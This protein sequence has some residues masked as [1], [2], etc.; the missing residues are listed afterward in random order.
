MTITEIAGGAVM[1][2]GK[3]NYYRLW[4]I[5]SIGRRLILNNGRYI[6]LFR[7]MVTFIIFAIIFSFISNFSYASLKIKDSEVKKVYIITTE[8]DSWVT[9]SIKDLKYYLEKVFKVEKVELISPSPELIEDDAALIY[10]GINEEIKSKFPEIQDLSIDGYII[11]SLTDGRGILITGKTPDG[12]ANGIY[13]FL[14]DFIG[15]RWFLPDEIFTYIPEK[16]PNIDLTKINTKV[17]PSFIPRLFSGFTGVDGANWA[18]RNRVD[19]GR[20]SLP[21]AAMSHNLY[22]IF[23]KEKFEKTHPEYFPLI[24][25]KRAIPEKLDGGNPQPC[26]SNPEV[27]DEA[28]KATLEFFKEN[29][30]AIT[31]SLSI[32]DTNTWCECKRCRALDGKRRFYREREIFSDRY[33]L[34]LN[35]I[36]KRLKKEMPGKFIGALAYS[37]TELPPRNIAKLSDNIGIWLTQ[38]TSQQ[39]DANYKRIDQKII[40]D[41]YKKG[42]RISK[43]DYYGLSW[44]TPRYYPHLIAEDIK[45]CKGH[46]VVGRFTEAYP[47]WATFGPMEYVGV[48]MQWNTSLDVDEL[49]NEFYKKMFK[50]S[51]SNI[52]NFYSILEKQWMKKRKGEWF[53]GLGDTE[54]HLTQ[55]P[56]NVMEKAKSELD[57]AKN[58]ILRSAQNDIYI[59]QRIEF[60]E[61]G[62]N[63]S[64]YLVKSYNAVQEIENNKKHIDSGKL[65]SLSNEYYTS[66]SKAKENY[67]N[68]IETKD[69]YPAPYY[70]G[71]DYIQ[72]LTKW[73]NSAKEKIIDNL[74]KLKDRKK[75][76][77]R[78][79]WSKIEKEIIHPDVIAFAKVKL[80]LDKMKNLLQDAGFEGT[81]TENLKWIREGDKFDT[82][83]PWFVWKK[84]EGEKVTPL[85]DE[86]FSHSGKKSAVISGETKGAFIQIIPVKPGEQYFLSTYVYAN[87]LGK[88]DRLPEFEIEWRK[89]DASPMERIFYDLAKLKVKKSWENVQ[90]IATVPEGASFGLVLLMI[91]DESPTQKVWFDDVFIGKIE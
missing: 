68:Y 10:V 83:I 59:K 14:E 46:G 77:N 35:E 45:F 7:A 19:R 49:L 33:F 44:Q 58:E 24:E 78:T 26:M 3:I 15:I 64:Y 91:N 86:S 16:E 28:Y 80:H 27:V 34:F 39:F 38:D 87:T 41:W 51:A 42:A 56:L 21:Y 85:I 1:K 53:Q 31:F 79:F 81:K 22:S 62:F 67:K 17:A 52:K 89:A 23:T 82:I 6:F 66:L 5:C 2:S 43:Y 70:R 47:F 55:F 48:K 76:D 54:Q 11:K 13:G 90:F 9:D 74:Q 88:K 20:P 18:R 75:I 60:I 69:I 84:E 72:M 4:N 25:G 12:T 65:I 63:Y 40:D 8:T 71:K 50:N 57:K 30:N 32:N 29:P 37:G 61:Q 36:A 73:E